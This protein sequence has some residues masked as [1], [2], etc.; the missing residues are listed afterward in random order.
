MIAREIGFLHTRKKYNKNETSYFC[1][2][3]EWSEWSEE[4]PNN[5]NGRVND[6]VRLM[7]FNLTGMLTREPS[8]HRYASFFR[9]IF[10]STLSSKVMGR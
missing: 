7:L 2:R 6:P 4:L 3:S 10:I 9:A 8:A 5:Q 1:C